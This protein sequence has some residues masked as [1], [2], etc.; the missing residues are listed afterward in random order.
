MVFSTTH[1]C[2]LV[3]TWK[4][5]CGGADAI[6]PGDIVS[7]LKNVVL[8]SAQSAQKMRLWLLSVYFCLEPRIEPK[9]KVKS[10]RM[11]RKE[12]YWEILIQSYGYQRWI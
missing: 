10:G 1:V 5:E 7:G 12:V 4:K 8:K 2:W 9:I 6:Y 3:L 11:N